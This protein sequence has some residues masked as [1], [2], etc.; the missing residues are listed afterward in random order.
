MLFLSLFFSSLWTSS[1]EKPATRVPLICRIWS[2][3]RRPAIA[4][5]LSFTTTQTNTPLLTACARRPTFLS[6]P[7]HR[8]SS[9]MPFVT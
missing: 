3:N 4:A 7:L 8:I 9:R 6:A 2:P 1:S 5:G